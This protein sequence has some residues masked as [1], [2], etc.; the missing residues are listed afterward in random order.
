MKRN[1]FRT[2]TVFTAE[3]FRYDAARIGDLVT[4]E[5][6]DNAMNILPPACMRADCSQMGEPYS[7]RIDPDNG[8]WRAVYATF[9]MVG[10]EDNEMLWQ[11]CGYCFR[12][13][14][15]E[16]GEEPTYTF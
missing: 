2:K 14:N 13:E 1:T 3:N 15:T 6:V 16:R 11:F 7:H 5:V 8:K 4:Q 9:K 10:V 12:G